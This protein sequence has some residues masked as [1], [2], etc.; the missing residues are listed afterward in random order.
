MYSVTRSRKNYA[1]VSSLEYCLLSNTVYLFE[2]IVLGAVLSVPHMQ[3]LS[4]RRCPLG[5]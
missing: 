2:A 3:R 5:L 1:P 4:V